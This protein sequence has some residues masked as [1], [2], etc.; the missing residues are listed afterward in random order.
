[1]A[2]TALC[3]GGGA[4]ARVVG[5]SVDATDV[6]DKG[7]MALC[8]SA[9]SLK[10]T[11][12]QIKLPPCI[13]DA[14]GGIGEFAAAVTGQ[15]ECKCTQKCTPIIMLTSN[16]LIINVFLECNGAGCRGR[17]RGLMI[18]NQQTG[19]FHG[20]RLCFKAFC[21]RCKCSKILNM[22]FQSVPFGVR[23]FQQFCPLYA[24]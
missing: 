7:T 23:Q 20:V 24:P 3:R 22:T 15:R 11:G 21:K 12:T 10:L 16:A 2:G 5:S 8:V 13:F 1:M 6:S 14:G 18:T 19:L 9:A 4:N 17:T